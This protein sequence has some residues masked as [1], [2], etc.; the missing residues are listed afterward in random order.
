[1]AS[2]D[3]EKKVFDQFTKQLPDFAGRPVQCAPG[4]NPPDFICTGRD[5]KRIG[6][7]L[8]EWLDETQISQER[9]QYQFEEEIL[10][11]IASR[12]EP[13][14]QNIGNIWIFENEGVGLDRSE[15]SEFRSQLYA[16]V[17]NLDRRWPTLEEPD[18]PQG[19]DIDDF[20]GYPM[21]QKYLSGMLCW[22][23]ARHRTYVGS[24]WIVFMNHGGGYSPDTAVEALD[25]TLSR[26][27]AKYQTLHRDQ[28]LAE[29]YLLLYYDQ[30]F[31]YNTPFEAPGHGFREI[32]QHLARIAER[33]HGVFQRIFLF[34][35][36]TKDIAQVY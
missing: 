1:M 23:Q 18:D 14:P 20:T 16:F 21:V 13:P 27:T 22:S 36:A 15:E 26:K 35:P 12:N 32:A 8:S 19:V 3:V 4:P 28:N 17:R 10:R 33:D 34:I 7:E 24:E 30:G 2:A 29:L 9:P 11:V 6:V 25:R 31:H 5:G